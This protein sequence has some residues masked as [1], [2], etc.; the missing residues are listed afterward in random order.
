MITYTLNETTYLEFI[1]SLR[2]KQRPNSLRFILGVLLLLAVAIFSWVIH[3][4]AFAVVIV[5]L[6]LSYIFYSQKIGKWSLRTRFRSNTLLSAI[7][8]INL[9]SEKIEGNIAGN[10]FS[11]LVSD[12]NYAV[13][14][15]K[16]ANIQHKTGISLYLPVSSMSSEEQELFQSVYVRM[17]S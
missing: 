8:E 9:T 6:T 11:L 12:I 10:S 17:P 4:Y 7:H 1:E 3:Q 15:D 13:V 14:N 2:S 16:V 5:G